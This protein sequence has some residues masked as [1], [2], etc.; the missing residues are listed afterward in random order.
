MRRFEGIHTL[1]I[2]AVL[3]GCTSGAEGRLPTEAAATLMP[4]ASPPAPPTGGRFRISIL[5]EL[6]QGATAHG[7]VWDGVT[8]PAQLPG[9]TWASSDTRV[10]D[11]VG[12][13]G[14]VASV[15]ARAAGTATVAASA[16]GVAV[17]LPVV[18]HPRPG[19]VTAP[20]AAPVLITDFRVGELADGRWPALVPLATLRSRDGRPLLLLEMELVVPGLPPLM[21]CFTNMA[22]ADVPRW[23]VGFAYGDWEV[24]YAPPAAREPGAEATLRIIV[25]D[26]AATTWLV[27][28][29]GPVEPVA[30]PTED[31]GGHPLGWH[32]AP[33]L[34][35][36]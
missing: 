36:P 7:E 3:A 8:G 33:R 10:L 24:A 11:I 30:L 1:A 32:C 22:L 35:L 23:L 6:V 20:D 15:G 31:F 16:P 12:T 4:G 26:G 17:R 21:P 18:V 14:P 28:A 29:R 9:T 2:A 13:L 34:E 5:P 25:R 27:E 19:Q